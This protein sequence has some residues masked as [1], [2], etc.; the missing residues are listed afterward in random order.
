[1]SAMNQTLLFHYTFV[2]GDLFRIMYEIVLL[3]LRSFR[4]VV[5]ILYSLY[6]ILKFHNIFSTH[7]E[8]ILFGFK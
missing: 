2:L 6:K 7:C 3:V 1:M 4:T 5:M 8:N